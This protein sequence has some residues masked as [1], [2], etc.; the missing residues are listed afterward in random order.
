MLE[1]RDLSSS[2]N[3]TDNQLPV[4]SKDDTNGYIADGAYT[5]SAFITF[6]T[7]TGAISRGGVETPISIDLS[8]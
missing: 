8:N 3:L 6:T 7:E 1:L 2:T 4:I 5:V